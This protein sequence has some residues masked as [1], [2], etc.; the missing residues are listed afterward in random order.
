MA[1]FKIENLLMENDK[2]KDVSS[3][4]EATLLNN[5]SNYNVTSYNSCGYRK[6]GNQVFLKG[7]VKSNTTLTTTTRYIFQL[8]YGY[9]PKK[10]TYVVG[11]YNGNPVNVII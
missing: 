7:M 6:I 8:P 3:W 11:N 2:I 4:I 10:S 5:W 9:R 1:N